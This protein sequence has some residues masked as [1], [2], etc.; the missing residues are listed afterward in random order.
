MTVTAP[1]DFA[2]PRLTRRT[3]VLGL[4]A[5][6]VV[7]AILRGVYLTADP[8]TAP[9][10]G[11]TWHDEGAWTHNARNKAL[12]GH[13]RTDEWNPVYVAPVFTF[14]EYASFATFGVGFWQ[15]RLVSVVMGLLSVI[16]LGL[17]MARV[18]GPI[19]GVMAGSFLAVNYVYVMFNRA[20]LM[21]TT[22]VSLLVVSWYAFVLAERRPRWGLLA[23]TAAVLAYFT[24]AA[25]AFFVVALAAASLW[26]LVDGRFGASRPSEA[27][28]RSVR[29][30][31]WTTAGLVLAGGAILASFVLPHWSE[32]W[33]YNWQVSVARKPTYSL[34]AM[35]DRASWFPIIHDSFTRAWFLLL[36]ALGAGLSHV[37]RWRALHPA[38]RLVLL[39]IVLGAAE[40]VV[41]DV[42]NERRLVLFFPP[43]AALA[44]TTLSER[45]LL[46]PSVA[47]LSRRRALIALPLVA[48]GFYM[49]AGAMLR[50][51]FLYETRPGVRLS[52][53]VAVLMTVLVYATWPRAA[54]RLSAEQWGIGASAV[55]ALLVIGG[56]LAQ[57]GQ[58]SWQRTY[59]NYNAARALAQ[60]LPPDTL[61]HG[62]L[63][64]G[65]A[66]ENRIR[67]V[68]VGNGFGNYAD[69][70]DRDDIKYL[71]TYVVPRLG[72][73]GPIIR[74]VLNRYPRWR[75]IRSFD[76]A[77]SAGG[78]DRA[79]LIDKGV[80]GK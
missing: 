45:R 52:A 59:K 10:V 15:A 74:D 39:W 62:K 29:A 11:V 19:A 54:Q 34:D 42:G 3:F 80:G 28:E 33:F 8:P 71:V 40:L 70:H 67:P 78:N 50:L 64:N 65:L 77:E 14:L 24:K 27:G 36:L 2:T 75:I 5:V 16:L 4:V 18:R 32:Y 31:W 43:M 61:V 60:W 66:L 38:E 79:A 55:L 6:A 30:A 25:A 9:P 51:F 21:E 63:A 76:V 57:F 46:V 72:Y 7:A 12:F 44:A 26:E 22:M 41:H 1:A 48:F 35:L 23:G 58:W 53:G 13:W 68:F 20:A 37:V 49:I 69:R 47:A 56:D 17:G 73:E